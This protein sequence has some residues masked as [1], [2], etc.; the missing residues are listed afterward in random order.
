[1]ISYLANLDR[2]PEQ[3]TIELGSAGSVDVFDLTQRLGHRMGL[4]SRAGPGSTDGEAFDR[5]ACAFD[6]PDGSDAFVHPDRMAAV[7]AIEKARRASR[8]GRGCRCHRRRG[9]PIQHR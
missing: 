4:A 6:T 2:A 8:A 3:T 7:A 9:A 1:V 5:L